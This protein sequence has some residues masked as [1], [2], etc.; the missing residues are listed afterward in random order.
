MSRMPKKTVF[1]SYEEKEGE[2]GSLVGNCD[3]RV[4]ARGLSKYLHKRKG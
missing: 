4:A 1:K 2:G 3:K